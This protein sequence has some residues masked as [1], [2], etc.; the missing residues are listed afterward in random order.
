MVVDFILSLALLILLAKI[1]GELSEKIGFPSLIGEI[2]AGIILGPQLLKFIE[3]TN[4]YRSFAEV[5]I[6][7]LIFLAGFQHGS[8]KELLKYKNTSIL[9]SFLSSTMPII[10]VVIFS[11]M[12]GFS[13]LT[14]L[15]LAVALGATSMGVSL[16]SLMGVREIG[17]RVGKTVI[18]SLVLNDMTGL[19]LLTGVVS[20]AEIVTGGG[21]NVLWQIGKVMLSVIIFFV[22]FYL[23]FVYLP[24]ITSR[25]MRFKVEEAKFSLAIIIILISAWVASNFGLSSIVGA[26]FSGVILSRS[27]AF[28]SHAFVEKVSSLS[29]GFFIPIFFAFTGAQL[30][31]QNFGVNITRALI[32]LCLITTVQIGCAFIAAKINRYSIREG[33]LVGLGMLPYGEVTLVVISALITFSL[34]KPDFFVGQNIQ[35][36]FSSVLLLITM[37]IFL[38]PLLMKLVNK[39]P[40]KKV[41][42]Q[43]AVKM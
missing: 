40:H 27:P 28:G 25:F 22:I 21:G 24:K 18:G 29:Y 9:I 41:K 8:I 30:I 35:G 15:F 37:S 10:A 36:L 33:L 1:L 16:R 7:L 26:F 23:G 32:F 38:T 12:Q 5:G 19:I 39:L 4:V 20:Y 14:S 31:F 34:A 43:K 3:L 17:T 13:L 11:L 6:I 42:I 2:V